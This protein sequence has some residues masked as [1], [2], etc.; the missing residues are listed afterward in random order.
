MCIYLSIEEI[1]KSMSTY[2]TFKPSLHHFCKIVIYNYVFVGFYSMPNLIV[3]M[4]NLMYPVFHVGFIC[5]GCV[6]ER[7]C[8]N[9]RQLKTKVVFASSSRVSFP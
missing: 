8:E 3:I 6:R 9:S 4:F 2:S 7:E 1:I 5:K